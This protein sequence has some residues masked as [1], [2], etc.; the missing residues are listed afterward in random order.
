MNQE[1]QEIKND[2]R[3]SAYLTSEEASKL[4]LIAKS[5]DR[6]VSWLAGAI[7]R[8]YLKAY[9]KENTI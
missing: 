1:H 6:S 3:V 7:L 5:N 9:E 8:E 4:T 2:T